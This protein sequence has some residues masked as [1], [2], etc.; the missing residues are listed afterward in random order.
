VTLAAENRRRPCAGPVFRAVALAAITL[1]DSPVFAQGIS[2]GVR[3][4]LN[5][6]TTATGGEGGDG[7]LEWQPRAVFGGFVTWRVTSWLELQPE[8]LYAMKGAK[9]E[10]FG[11]TAKILLDYIE[12]PALARLS[13]GAR[14]ARSWYLVAGP[15]LSFLTRARSRADFGGAIEEIDLTDDVERF[16]IGVA[17]GGGV[18]FGSLLVD[19]RY[20]HGLSD[21]DA[22]ATDDVTVRNRAV[23]LTVG[24]KF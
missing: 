6:A 1:C 16:D 13:R 19:A 15:S 5:M 18:E 21:I 2:T 17:A 4:G 3:G 8:V 24:F 10:E 14:G 23:S 7:A 11:L 9:S 20:N 22:D 12:V